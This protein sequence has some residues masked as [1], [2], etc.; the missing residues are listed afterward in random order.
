M[1]GILVGWKVH[2][3]WW[4]PD[5]FLS[6][7]ELWLIKYQSEWIKETRCYIKYDPWFRQVTTNYKNSELKGNISNFYEV[8]LWMILVRAAWHLK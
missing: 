2:L 8:Y 4:Y 6:L 3:V 1:A 5:V 7:R